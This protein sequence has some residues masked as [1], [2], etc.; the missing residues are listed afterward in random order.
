MVYGYRRSTRNRRQFAQPMAY[1]RRATRS[2]GRSYARRR[3]SV[4]AAPSTR[5]RRAPVRRRA[6]SYAGGSPQ[7]MSGTGHG[8]KYI[9]SQADPF[10]ENVDG[11][12]IPDAN[13]QPSVALKCEDTFDTTLGATY[14]CTAQAF[15]PALPATRVRPVPASD[16]SWT[17]F[18]S[19]TG[20]DGASKLT[21]ART[22]FEML[23]PV[24]HAIRITSGLAP[25]AAK[26]FIHVCV[27]SQSLY[28]S[29]TWTYPTSVSLMQNVPGYKRIPIGRLTAEGLTVVNRP[30]DVTSQRYIDSDSPVYAEAGT[31]E[32]QTG[33]QWC[34]I[35]VAVTGCDVSS[36]PISVES[37]IHL[38]CIPRATAVSMSTPSAKYNVQA[39]AAAANAQAKTSP[40]ALD[41]EKPARKQSALE[42]AMNML[43]GASRGGTGSYFS[44]LI[45]RRAQSAS[46]ATMGSGGGIRNDVSSSKGM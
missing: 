13:A 22:D 43:G 26:G 6:Q 46:N 4:R 15:N 2:Y 8:D 9:L 7:K 45:G 5:R 34:S 11:V 35:I 37:I 24:A 31:M 18:G 21:Q 40:S 30:L 20:N 38:E 23:R 32:F 25:T 27:H 3:P 14:G 19:F 41:S 1:G 28:Q 12:K 29:N 17:W 16:T 39:L 44:K 36:T 42:N 33:L 10:D